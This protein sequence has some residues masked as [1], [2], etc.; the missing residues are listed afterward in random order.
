M[1]A[2]SSV[3]G[4]GSAHID[5]LLQSPQWTSTSITYSFPTAKSDVAW[6]ATY[7]SGNTFEE[8][9]S[10]QK[11]SVERALENCSS[12]LKVGLRPEESST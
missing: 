11:L 2:I 5:G 3:T 10:A 9:N 1:T 7:R 4:S 8:F 12:V 6:F